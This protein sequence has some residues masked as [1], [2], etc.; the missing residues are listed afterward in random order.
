FEIGG[1]DSKYIS[2]ENGVVVNFEMN[3]VCAAGTGSFLEE[4]AE[5][6]EINI[7]KEFENLA[8]QCESPAKFGERCTVFIES[9]LVTHQQAG[10]SKEELVS[11][12][13]Y[14]IVQNYLNKVVMKKKIGN[15]IF[16]QGGTANNM[17][18]V[19]AFEKIL[20][21][22]I[23][24]PPH[25]D[26][27][28]AIGIAILSMESTA[29]RESKFKGF[30]FSHC[31]YTLKPFV[32]KKCS[33]RCE[34]KM[35]KSEN[36]KPLFYGSRCERY[37]FDKKIS[38]GENFPDIFDIR[39]RLLL[40]EYYDK[41]ESGRIFKKEEK[42]TGPGKVRVGI[43]RMLQF[44]ENFPYWKTFFQS[45]GWEVVLSDRTSKE[46][47]EESTGYV[48]AEFCLPI[49]AAFGHAANLLKKDIDY[50]FMPSLISQPKL[51]EEYSNAYNCP[52]VQSI[53]YIL[54]SGIDIEKEGI[55]IIEP[56]LHMQKG[57]KFI[58]KELV[59]TLKP[60]NVKHSAVV[61]ALN[62]AEM[63]DKQFTEEMKKIG[64]SVIADL[65]KGV[66]KKAVVLVGRSYNTCDDGLN[67]GVPKKFRDLGVIALPMD[68]LRL[69]ETEVWREF[70]NMYWKYGQKILSVSEIG[71]KYKNL[72]SVYITN[73]GCGPDSMINHVFQHKMGDMPYLQLELDEHTADAGVLTRCEAFLD[74]IKSIEGKEF[75]AEA[76]SLVSEQKTIEKL[77]IPYMCDHALAVAAAFRNS[78]IDAEVL[79]HP[80]VESSDLGR[81]FTS[82]KECY[83]CI[84]SIGDMVR[85]IQ[86][87][88]FDM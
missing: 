36:E 88:D 86:D 48:T 50:L 68:L 76:P 84:V 43:P 65:E 39:E 31:E 45:I 85:K 4:Q 55:K 5:R 14:S 62:D 2:L 34:V 26:V 40:G 30:D 66:Y 25:N 35:V 1:Q 46:I 53:P 32:C 58:E 44:Y 61:M 52:Y 38:L 6:L 21:K 10:A 81:R 19:A 11:G 18:V 87:S 79:P 75:A 51:A 82:G 42:I 77:Y 23:T 57:R 24:V 16:F 7:K 83:P 69:D 74:S 22:K 47:I 37:D 70:P 80:T 33:N 63:A 54:R 41:S 56:H 15:N 28:G 13:A 27:I 71:K 20:D 49:K 67:I 17:S 9:D 60:F 72:Y 78:G 64:D 12:L 59:R 8:M 29:G 73:F 3:K